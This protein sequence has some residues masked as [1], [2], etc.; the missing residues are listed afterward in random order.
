MSKLLIYLV[1]IFCL[2]MYFSFS[3]KGGGKEQPTI[4]DFDAAGSGHGGSMVSSGGSTAGNGASFVSN[5][6]GAATKYQIVSRDGAKGIVKLPDG[7]YVN[8]TLSATGQI[9]KLGSIKQWYAGDFHTDII[10]DLHSS[11]RKTW[12]E[13]DTHRT[14]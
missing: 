5:A 1:A 9:V 7:T 14:I 11:K 6:A 8:A 2:W 4:E 12:A 3:G 13:Q 10:T